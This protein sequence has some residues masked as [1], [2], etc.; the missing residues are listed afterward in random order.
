MA[1]HK[2]KLLH[3]VG[4]WVGPATPAVLE[5]RLRAGGHGEAHVRARMAEGEQQELARALVEGGWGV[6]GKDLSPHHPG[7]EFV[8]A[9]D[10]GDLAAAQARLR[11]VVREHGTPPWLQ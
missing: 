2:D 7:L 8:A 5:R 11:D 3:F 1:Q 4:V 10:S 9:I 6:K